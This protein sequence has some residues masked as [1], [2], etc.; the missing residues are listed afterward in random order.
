MVWYSHLFKNIPEYVLIPTAKGFS[1]V[2][3]AEQDVFLEFSLSFFSYDLI[4]VGNLVS[5][6][7]AFLN[8]ACTS[9]SS[10]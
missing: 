4:D 7:S 9:G 1:T 3:K 8:Q 5:C 6:S 2:N 10:R